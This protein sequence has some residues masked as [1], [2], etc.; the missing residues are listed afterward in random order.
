MPECFWVSGVGSTGTGIPDGGFLG[1]GVPG[2]TVVLVA[3]VV[4]DKGLDGMREEGDRKS[5]V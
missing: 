1:R 3:V 4:E 2:I 5:V